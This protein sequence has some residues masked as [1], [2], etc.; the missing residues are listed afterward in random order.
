LPL[1]DPVTKQVA[2]V[3]T[4]ASG[5]SQVAMALAKELGNIELVSADSMAIYRGMDLATAKASVADRNLVPHHLIDIADP[6]EEFSVAAFQAAGVAALASVAKRG[7]HAIVV[8]GSGL[9]QRSLIDQ[10]EIPPMYPEHRAQLEAEVAEGKMP[11][12][13]GELLAADPEAASRIEASNA[14][15]LV[16]ALEVIRGGAGKF[17]DHAPSLKSYPETAIPQWG[18]S[19]APELV[20]QR[21]EERF[22]TWI[23]AGLV[24]EV[25]ALLSLGKPL[26]R[27]ALQAAGYAE[28]IEHL[29]GAISL[30]EAVARSCARSRQLARRQW[31]W[32]RRDPRITWLA[33]P[34]EAIYAMRE[35]LQDPESPKVDRLARK[36]AQAS[37]ATS[38]A[39][40]G[41]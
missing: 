24:E 19:F 38:P 10:L 17:S 7:N 21:I 32:F 15:R 4:T 26:N 13:Y 14:R 6:T 33:S 5:K 12:L 35:V 37:L 8:G 20:D 29:S 11:E 36:A 27:T 34:D 31:R 23:A 41:R 1:A 3:G 25:E 39:V 18:I 2:I 30:D 28:M 40:V 22:A 9:Y 16:R